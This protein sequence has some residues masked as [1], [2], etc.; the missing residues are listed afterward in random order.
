MT[1]MLKTG[2]HT[3]VDYKK[4][5]LMW[6]KLKKELDLIGSLPYSLAIDL[7]DLFKVERNVEYI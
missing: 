1:S 2:L 6:A 7:C 3:L 4:Y 5:I